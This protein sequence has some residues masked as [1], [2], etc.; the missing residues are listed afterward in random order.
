M[1][2]T[3]RSGII[4]IYNWKLNSIQ[5]QVSD[6][7]SRAAML[8]IIPALLQMFAGANGYYCL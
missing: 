2:G 8:N 4:R 1:W 6:N 3:L 7:I 5:Q